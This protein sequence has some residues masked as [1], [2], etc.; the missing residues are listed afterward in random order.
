MISLTSSVMGE[1]SG[2][3]SVLSVLEAGGGGD[4][5][6]AGHSPTESVREERTFLFES[7]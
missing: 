5:L 1:S 6:E 2:R 4:L 3:T 7:Y